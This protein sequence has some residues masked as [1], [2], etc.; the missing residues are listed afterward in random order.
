[1]FSIYGGQDRLI[2]KYD[3]QGYFTVGSA[4]K[5]IRQNSTL[6]HSNI[7]WKVFWEMKLP[8]KILTFVWKLYFDALPLGSKLHQIILG[9]NPACPFCGFSEEMTLHLFF[10]CEFPNKNITYWFRNSI[11]VS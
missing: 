9:F 8:A 4:Y 5:L 7:N 11:F 6:D 3:Y 1:M 2:W 10:D